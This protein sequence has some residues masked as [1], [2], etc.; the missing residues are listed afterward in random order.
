MRLTDISP[1]QEADAFSSQIHDD[2][3]LIRMR[4]FLP[5]VV[6]GLFFG[7]FWPLSTPFGTID[8]EARL[9]PGSGLAPAKV[10]GVPLREDPQTIES[11]SQDGQQSID[12]IVHA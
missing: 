10:V 5:T 7:V 1:A 4:L 9:G 8:D 11:L 6:E 2:D 12:P 3:I